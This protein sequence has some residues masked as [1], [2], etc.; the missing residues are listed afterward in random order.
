[1]KVAF[2]VH[3]FPVI[4][5]AFIVNAAVGLIDAGHTVDIYALDG[6]ANAKGERHALV[7]RYRLEDRTHAFRLNGLPRRQ[8]ALAPVAALRIAASHGLRAGSV[9]DAEC[10][11]PERLG[12]RALHEANL[13]RR[14]GKYDILHCH[15]GTLADAVLDHRGA[16]FLSGQVVVHFRGYD[17][18]KFV[19]ERGERAYDRVFREADA[20]VANCGFFR[21][22]AV[23]LGSPADRTHVVG[24]GVA[25]ERF[26]FA[27]RSWT[28][29][30][31]L[32]LLGIGRLVEKKGFRF[33]IEAVARLVSEGVD[34]RLKIAGGGALLAALKDQATALGIADRVIFVGA[35]AHEQIATL[36]DESH[37]LLAPSTTASN[38]DRDASINTVKEAMAA[39]CPFVTSDHGGIPEL[40]EG[41]SAGVMVREGDA[42]ALTAGLRQLLARR[43][44]WAEMSRRGRAHVLS[45]YSI[46]A[47]TAE[48]LQV[49]ERAI[50]SRSPQSSRKR[51]VS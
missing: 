36:L 35:V 18:S 9:L 28:P 5:E 42:E 38:G 43:G 8:A 30:E 10:F 48:T 11:G 3:R 40:V 25:V 33:A 12:L 13:F 14:N 45:R 7:E 34:A 31:P 17:I 37:I 1:M 23:A 16:G 27:A 50:A 20:F 46:E 47:V 19:Q 21:D 6:P 4:S 24:S 49:Y 15:F 39:G 44:E 22:R 32:Q 51:N 29:G 2:F 41:V 26:R